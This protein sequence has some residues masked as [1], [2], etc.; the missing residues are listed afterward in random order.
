MTRGMS[1]ACKSDSN[2]DTA[3][4]SALNSGVG[5]CISLFN[6]RCGMTYLGVSV[7]AYLS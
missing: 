5:F 4:A 2:L 1:D 7:N 3:S 6:E